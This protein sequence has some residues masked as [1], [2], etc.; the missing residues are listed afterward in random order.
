MTT[1]VG[2][3][4]SLYHADFRDTL[5]KVAEEGG[6]DL[7]ATSPPYADARTYGM[8]VQFTDTDYQDLA[9]AMWG[10]LRPGGH[11]LVNI[12]APV[13]DWM[14]DRRGTE[15]GLHPWRFVLYAHDVVGFRVPDRL[16]FGRMGAPGAYAGR[17]RNDWEPLFWLQRPG[18]AGFFDRHVLAERSTYRLQ[19]GGASSRRTDGTIFSR[20]RSGWAVD[21]GMR[22]RGT[23]W[24]YGSGSCNNT[25]APDIE[26]AGHPARWPYKLSRDLVLC[27]SP[28]GGL[29]CDPFLGAGTTMIAALEEGR[30]FI[31][32]DVGSRPD[33]SRWVDIAAELW[34]ARIRQGRPLSSDLQAFCVQQSDE[35]SD[36]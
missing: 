33:G 22:H 7:I 19:K 21:N 32:G 20:E 13:R 11:A 15:R 18:A 27:F 14:G 26:A 1:I 2:E 8:G 3:G 4:Y 5:A 12:D 16:A 17:F 28:P 36:E 9:Q 10:A 6:C 25:G 35:V 31:G 34:A 29:V 30:Q 24:D 23:L